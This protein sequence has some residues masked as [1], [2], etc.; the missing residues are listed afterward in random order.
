[1]ACIAR[2]GRRTVA[3]AAASFV[4]VVLA[5]TV[6]PR[7]ASASPPTQTVFVNEGFRDAT[8]GP[9]Y[10]LPNAP[11]GV[12]SACLTAGTDTT[13]T[14][15][16]GCGGIDAPGSG[17]LRLTSNLQAEEGGVGSTESVPIT[18]GLDAVFDSYQYKPVG[19]AFGDGDGLGF[20]LAATDPLN[21]TV[22][23]TIGIPGGALGY[24]PVPGGGHNGLAY[25]YLGVGLDVYGNYLNPAEDGTDCNGSDSFHDSGP[26]SLPNS[27]SVRG[28]GDGTTGYC[29]LSADTALDGTL[30]GTTRA[31][32]IV[33]V[34]VLINPSNSASV[35]TSGSNITVPAGSYAVVFTPFGG[36]KQ[37]LT[38]P[39]PS[40][41][42]G[43]IPAGLYPSSWIDPTTGY[44]YKLTY[45][46]VGSTGGAVDIHEVNNV[47]AQTVNGAVPTLSATATDAGSGSV[48]HDA[49][50]TL[51][52]TPTVTTDGGA[53]DQPIQAT[54]TFPTGTT[55][56]T[57]TSSPWVCSISIQTETCTYTPG[58][59]IAAGTA[60]TALELP[61][62][63]NGP[64]ATTTIPWVVAST[65][66]TA[67]TGSLTL[68]ITHA[69]SR[70]SASAA[71][72]S[73]GGPVSMSAAVL[74][75]DAT[76]T[77]TFTDTTTGSPICTAT[78]S[79]GP[80]SCT[81]TALPPATVHSIAV[82]YSGDGR[83]DA[84]S[85]T[86][87][88]SLSAGASSITAVASPTSVPYSTTS[89]LSVSGLSSDATGTITFN[90]GGTTLCT[91]RLPAT[92]CITATTLP[93]AAYTVTAV[94]SGDNNY[95]TTTAPTTPLTITQ[96]TPTVAESTS[97]T[98]IEY[99]TSATLT[100]TG[101]PAGAT[102]AVT[103]SGPGPVTL[104][105][106]TLPVTSCASST[107]LAVGTYPITATYPGDGNVSAA[108]STT[109]SL[110][111]TQAH[112]T[113]TESASTL[114]IPYGATSTLTASGLPAGAT[115]TITFAWS[116]PVT[117]CTAT[118][119]STSCTTPPGLTAG[120]YAVTATYSGDSNV[121]PTQASGITLTQNA[122]L[123][124][125]FDLAD[126]G[127]PALGL[128]GLGLSLLI[129]G[130][131]TL[132]M[133]RRR[134]QNRLKSSM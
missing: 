38:G 51:T 75:A 35:S 119:P 118:L 94:Y 66:A 134:N 86:T 23:S 80:A 44:P 65:D 127:T 120:T 123:L 124:A 8:A 128:T 46:W 130:L 55:P 67:V 27:V 121:A 103:F 92:T 108:T 122:A 56:T 63:A 105:T 3:L 52:I 29:V 87:T 16:P 42:N 14:P 40:T 4:L 2:S 28:A 126:T 77:V 39:L 26:G 17:A 64:P 54:V 83:Y 78:V 33:P 36:T 81:G 132:K 37:T 93:A 5:V 1:M 113:L 25:G 73:V 102:G 84:S 32:S 45:S 72:G 47:Q 50:D 101:L 104:C 43:G 91:A 100:I 99:G 49:S 19:S 9:N 109:A 7:S 61:F 82:A 117:L 115:G 68:T 18:K 58:S 41:L 112:P 116:D 129:T 6:A 88:L 131:V 20:Y 107:L 34:E 111:I 96:V 133:A 11:A 74:P 89:T 31:N 13:Q 22:P 71:I 48:A 60:L 10:L 97:A 125:V 106:T 114:T 70:V 69:T 98:S 90:A 24:S 59:A 57:A 30:L 85:T 15:I 12:N 21:P 79:A 110:Q 76:G 53:E 95:A 62:T